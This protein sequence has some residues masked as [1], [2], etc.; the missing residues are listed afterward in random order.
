[1]LKSVL[2]EEAITTMFSEKY[3]LEYFMGWDQDKIEENHRQRLKE[4]IRNAK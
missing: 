1:M 3:A 2:G 4:Q